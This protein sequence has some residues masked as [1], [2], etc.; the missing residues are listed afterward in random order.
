[1]PGRVAAIRNVQAERKQ[2]MGASSENAGRVMAARKH[3]IHKRKWLCCFLLCILCFLAAI[4][5]PAFSDEA[6]M[7]CFR[8]AWTFLIAATLPGILS[9]QGYAPEIAAGKMT[10]AD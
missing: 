2:S 5:L 10:P 4:T 3:K 9:A 6:T 7:L 8:S 1:M